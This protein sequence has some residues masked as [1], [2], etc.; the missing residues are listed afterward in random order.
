MKKN[1]KIQ[2]EKLTYFVFRNLEG[3]ADLKKI[4]GVDFM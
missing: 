2:Q 4:S 1:D 3:L